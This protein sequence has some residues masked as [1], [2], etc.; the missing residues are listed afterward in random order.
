[1]KLHI[2]S[3]SPTKY[4]ALRD[5]LPFIKPDDTVIFI[6]DGVYTCLVNNKETRELAGIKCDITALADDLKI[7]GIETNNSLAKAIE[8]AD[9]VNLAFKA[10]QTI[11]WF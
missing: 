4:T 9:F 6:D 7:R 11:S 3:K 1:M 5:A 10:N 8:M 2:I